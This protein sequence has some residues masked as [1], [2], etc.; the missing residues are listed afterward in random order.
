M[1]HQNASSRQ[2][3]TSQL[4][5]PNAPRPP[6]DG[7]VA[8]ADAVAL[9]MNNPHPL[10][11]LSDPASYGASGAISRFHNPDNYTRALT[12]LLQR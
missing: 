11:T 7:G 6:Q 2:L 5:K 3:T 10:S 9:F 4:T 1:G 8:L 12:A